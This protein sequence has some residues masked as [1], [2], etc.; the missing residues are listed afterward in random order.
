MLKTLRTVG[1]ALGLG[2]ALAGAS[3]AQEATPAATITPPDGPRS[4]TPP[5]T[6]TTDHSKFEILQQD[7]KSGPE[8][9]AACLTCHTLADDQVMH[10]L[11]FTWN[12]ESDL[13][14][15]LGKRTEINAFCGNVVGN[16]PRCT[17][18]HAG[19]GW[20]DMHSAPPQQSTAVDCLA[21]H[22]RSGQYTKTATGAGHP[23][24]DPV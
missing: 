1:L 13:G 8:V 11:H 3:L 6:A 2:V 16:E 7:F 21:C 9:T 19:Y 12:Y 22:D 4:I 23:P 5:S 24:L 20:D 15:T 17:S 14:Q 18:C 10:S